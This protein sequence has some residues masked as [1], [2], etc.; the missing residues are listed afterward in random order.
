MQRILS[1][2]ANFP[3]EGWTPYY[4]V[5]WASLDPVP[6]SLQK[7]ER[8]RSRDPFPARPK[9]QQECDATQYGYQLC[10]TASAVWQCVCMY[11]RVCINVLHLYCMFFS[12]FYFRLCCFYL[13]VFTC[14][15]FVFLDFLAFS[16]CYVIWLVSSS[17]LILL[18]FLF[19]FIGFPLFS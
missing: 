18:Y 19:I 3:E 9:A 11:V 1:R 8:N 7:K 6:P 12:F 5:P 16:L 10:E 13:N 17:S 15:L 2:I 14:I 4:Q